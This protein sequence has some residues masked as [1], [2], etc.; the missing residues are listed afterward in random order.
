MITWIY[1]QD[2]TEDVELTIDGKITILKNVKMQKYGEIDFMS[3]P[4]GEITAT[5]LYDYEEYP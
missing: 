1:N 4:E 2:G 3:E 5:F